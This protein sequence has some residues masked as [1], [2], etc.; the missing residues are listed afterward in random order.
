MEPCINFA[1]AVMQDSDPTN[2]LAAIRELP[3]EKRYVWRVASALKW[4]FADF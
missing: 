1:M 4:G 3:F 2:E